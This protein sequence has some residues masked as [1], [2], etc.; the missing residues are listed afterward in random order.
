MAGSKL[1]GRVYWVP[2][3]AAIHRGGPLAGDLTVFV[4]KTDHAAVWATVSI[5]ARGQ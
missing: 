2:A 4:T 5:I 1:M 3:R